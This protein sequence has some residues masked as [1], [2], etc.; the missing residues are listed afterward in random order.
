MTDGSGSRVLFLDDSGKPSLQHSSGAVVIAGFSVP[1]DQA[2][3][4]SRRVAGA[5]SRYFRD[6]GDPA[7]WEI[8]A[9]RTINPSPWK[10]AKNRN[11]L[12]EVARILRILDCTVYTVSI[13]KRNMRHPMTLETTMSWQMQVLVEHFA[14]E[15]ASG[16]ETGMVVSD[17]SNHQL[18]AR[19]SASVGSFVIAGGLPLHPTVYYANSSSSHAI[20]AADLIAGIH[21]RSVEGDTNMHLLDDRLAGIRSRAA[22]LSTTT[23]SGRSYS[24]RI[25][26]I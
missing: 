4:L 7:R 8:K 9:N 13:D 1:A 12:G 21:R 6:R 23:Q 17:W 3:K 10:R 2:P 25:A 14:A 26:L 11:F 15:C 20:Q 18:D 16:G 22:R 24:N 19:V 5:K